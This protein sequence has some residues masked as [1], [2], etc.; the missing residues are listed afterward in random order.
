MREI[1]IKVREEYNKG[2][3]LGLC[4]AADNVFGNRTKEYKL[5]KKYLN[6]NTDPNERYDLLG[7]NNL[8]GPWYW[9]VHDKESRLNWLDEH[10]NKQEL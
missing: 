7:K 9:D 1:L 10:I 3:T 4:V 8:A 5:F 2:C 6:T